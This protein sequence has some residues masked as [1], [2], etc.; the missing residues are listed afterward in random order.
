[1]SELNRLNPSLHTECP[2]G[3]HFVVVEVLE[4][5]LDLLHQLDPKDVKWMQDV[6]G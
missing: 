6:L 4:D 5:A 1:V 3:L 2:E